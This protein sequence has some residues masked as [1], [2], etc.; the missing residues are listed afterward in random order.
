MK[1]L[2]K[3]VFDK[4]APYWKKIADSL[5][6][7]IPVIRS[8]E[9]RCLK[10]DYECCDGVLRD[11][12]SSDHGLQPKTWKT[13]ITALQDTKQF[14]TLAPVIEKQLQSKLNIHHFNVIHNRVNFQL[15]VLPQLIQLLK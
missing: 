1:Y 6:F 2:N 8:I 12:I 10:D 15:L 14:A 9:K 5:E 4:I 11:W 13:F 3:L 7:D